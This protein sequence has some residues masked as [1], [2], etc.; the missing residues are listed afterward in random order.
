LTIAK[1]RIDGKVA[2]HISCAIEG[3]ADL[4]FTTDNDIIKRA[5][6]VTGIKIVNPVWFFIEE[7]RSEEGP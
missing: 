6:A 1:H 3:G 4:F 7:A 2:L 5:G